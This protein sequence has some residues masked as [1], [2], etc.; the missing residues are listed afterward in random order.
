MTSPRLLALALALAFRFF[1]LERD[2]PSGVAGTRQ[3]FDCT[4]QSLGLFGQ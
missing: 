3:F 4:H 2:S 1:A